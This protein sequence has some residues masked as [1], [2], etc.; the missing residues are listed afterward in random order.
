MG[1]VDKIIFQG[2]VVDYDDPLRLGR[3][4]VIPESENVNEIKET[5]TQA[6]KDSNDTQ[7]GIKSKCKWTKDDPFTIIP[8]LPYSLN[9]TPKVGELVHIIYPVVQNGKS[10]SRKYADRAKCYIPSIPSTPLSMAY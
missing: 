5:I 1:Q 3:L 2:R 8:L 9:V 4:R 10:Q 7:T 6:C